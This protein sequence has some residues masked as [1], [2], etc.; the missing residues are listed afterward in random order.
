MAR[1]NMEKNSRALADL[2][3]LGQDQICFPPFIWEELME[4]L[5]DLSAKVNKCG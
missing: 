2:R 3:F 5:E 1:S 4:L